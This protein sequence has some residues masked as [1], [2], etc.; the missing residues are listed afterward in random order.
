MNEDDGYS[1]KKDPQNITIWLCVCSL[2]ETVGQG[3]MLGWVYNCVHVRM[4]IVTSIYRIL[5]SSL[6][7]FSKSQSSLCIQKNCFIPR[8]QYCTQVNIKRHV[9]VDEFAFKTAAQ[10]CRANEWPRLSFHLCK[11]AYWGP[12]MVSTNENLVQ[13]TKSRYLCRT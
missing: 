11:K 10:L 8:R 2:V 1:S 3:G 12:G 5:F 7:F 4:K 6:I 13:R 9:N